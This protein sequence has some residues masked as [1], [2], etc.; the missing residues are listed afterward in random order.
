MKLPTV[1]AICAIGKCGQLGLNGKLPWYDS[2]DL[3]RFKTLTWGGVLI[4]GFNT[5]VNMPRLKGRTLY[6]PK[7]D[8]MPVETLY[9]LNHATD[10]FL[11]GGG[12][13]FAKFA[14]AGLIRHWDITKVDYDGPS[15][16]WFDPSW[17]I[18]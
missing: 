12:K 2:D 16:V 5:Y 1:T 6:V 4:C 11:I 14:E 13:T 9:R 8:E 3:K 18:M 17:L 15:D 10:L 7:D